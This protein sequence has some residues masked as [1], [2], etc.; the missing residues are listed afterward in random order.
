MSHGVLL[1]A[2]GA[3]QSVDDVEEYYTRIRGGRRPTD[4]EIEDLRARYERIGG[5]S[6]LVDI[7]RRQASALEASMAEAGFSVPVRC[8]M[9]FWDPSVADAL[10]ELTDAGVDRIVALTMGPYDSRISVG[11]YERALRQAHKA[12]GTSVEVELVRHW[13]DAPGLDAAWRSRFDD[14]LNATGWDVASTR[15]LFSAHALPERILLWNDAYPRQFVAHG[16]ELASEWGLPR[17]GFTYQSAGAAGTQRWTGPDVLDA[18][19]HA[20]EMGDEC[21]LVVPVGFSADH[22]EILHDLDVEA[23]RRAED[24]GIAFARAGSLNDHPH[25]IQALR[26]KVGERLGVDIQAAALDA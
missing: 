3:V 17:W 5:R 20:K 19:A 2:F 16:T 9:R 25:F 11:G 4:A 1:M 7:A 14:A 13:F 23:R 24:V 12:A 26:S 15:V 10:A 6:P 22:L 18:L 8:G 21:V